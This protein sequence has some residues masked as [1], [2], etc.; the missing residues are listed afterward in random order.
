MSLNVLRLLHLIVHQ[1]SIGIYAL[2]IK[3]NG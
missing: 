2:G 3:N 1:I